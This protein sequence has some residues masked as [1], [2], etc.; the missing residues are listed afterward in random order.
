MTTIRSFEEVMDVIRH[1]EVEV[2]S[3][4]IAKIYAVLNN[5]T[6]ITELL[7]NGGTITTKIRSELEFFIKQ[8]IINIID[9][10]IKRTCGDDIMNTNRLKM[11]KLDTLRDLRLLEFDVL[12]QCDHAA[13]INRSGDDDT[14][15]DQS[16]ISNLFD[17][18]ADLMVRF[19]SV[20][21]YSEQTK[22]KINI[23][24]Q[25][26]D[27][28]SVT[29][30]ALLGHTIANVIKAI[31]I[32]KSHYGEDYSNKSSNELVFDEFVQYSNLGSMSLA[33]ILCCYKNTNLLNLAVINENASLGHTERNLMLNLMILNKT[34]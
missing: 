28:C 29:V 10:C 1:N 18:L 9:S 32:A 20:S 11:C 31:L 13:Y 17:V 15:L 16:Y 27:V 12:R 34:S 7:A 6:Y 33:G 3:D 23:V 25:D 14:T 2:A 24:D 19:Y 4:E 5:N 22:R 26:K 21:V 30:I 8:R